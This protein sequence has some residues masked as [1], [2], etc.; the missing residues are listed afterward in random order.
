MLF[1]ETHRQGGNKSTVFTR[2]K[3]EF[4]S[5]EL[6][7]IVV[8]HLSNVSLSEDDMTVV[9]QRAFYMFSVLPSTICI[10]LYDE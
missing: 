7:N 6:E 9:D 3:F 5:S 4:V 2:S 10:G 8:N 1:S